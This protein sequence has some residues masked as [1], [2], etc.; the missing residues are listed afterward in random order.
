[1]AKGPKS[2]MEVVK[3]AVLD[4][5]GPGS[6]YRW[7]RRHHDDVVVMLSQVSRPNWR[8][9]A[10]AMADLNLKDGAN[11]VPNS[12]RVR[13]TW[14]KVRR[15]VAAYRAKKPAVKETPAPIVPRP[16]DPSPSPTK[17]TPT[18]LK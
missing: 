15:D 9:F 6:L 14:V 4:P 2:D 7:L 12:E 18:K 8:D 1:M 13:Q 5:T 17:W 3:A 16:A 10:K 11:N